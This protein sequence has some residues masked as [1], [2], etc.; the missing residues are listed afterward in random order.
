MA[1]MT[2]NPKK[3]GYL[4]PKGCKD[5]IDVL[6]GK[7]G[8]PLSIGKARVRI[9]DLIEAPS[10]RVIDEAGKFCGI[11]TLAEALEMARSRHLDLVEIIPR[12][13]PPVCVIIDWAK[14]LR[15]QQKSSY[16][17]MWSFTDKPA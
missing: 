11:K 8:K 1:G 2:P 17:A 13:K 4:L 3:R 15:E 12:A 5:L 7:P 10:V 16:T 14:D 6:N 9:N